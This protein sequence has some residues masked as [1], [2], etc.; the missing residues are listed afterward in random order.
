MSAP[1]IAGPASCWSVMPL[2]PPAR[3]PAPAPTR[4]S[5]TSRSSATSISPPGSRPK[6]WTR[7]R[8]PRSTRIRS[9]KPATPG[10]RRRHSASARSRSTTGSTGRRSVGRVS[11][12]GSAKAQCGVHATE[13]TR[14]R[15]PAITPRR[16]HRRHRRL[17]CRRPPDRPRCAAYGPGRPRACGRCRWQRA[18]ARASRVRS[19]GRLKSR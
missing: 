11:W 1:A 13:L 14:G 12:P 8:S 6:A 4:C 2:R 16:R 3:L 7:P 15:S 19:P 17:H 18:I 5:R 10:R 9:S